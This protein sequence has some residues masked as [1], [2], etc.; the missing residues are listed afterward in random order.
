MRIVV[1]PPPEPSPMPSFPLLRLLAPLVVLAL[2]PGCRDDAAGDPADPVTPA[3]GSVGRYRKARDARS[4]DDK[5]D[6]LEGVGYL[7]GSKQAGLRRGV[8]AHDPDRAAAGP[9]LYLSGH[10]P[11]AVLMDMDGTRLHE[12]RYDFEDAFPGFPT[13]KME[14]SHMRQYWRRAWLSERG[15]LLAIFEGH[16]MLKLSPTSEL[17]WTFEGKPHHDLEVT[18]DGEIYVLTRTAHVIPRIHPTEPVLEDFVSVLDRDGNETRRVSVLEAFENS[19]FA[20]TLSRM[21]RHG[22]LLHTNTIE[23]LDG[24]LA[25]AVPAFAAGNVL[26][27]CLKTSTIAVIDL[28]AAQVVWAMNGSFVR[29]HQPTVLDNGRLLLFDNLGGKDLTIGRSRVLELDPATRE[30]AWSYEGTAE[31]PFQ[32]DTC[33]SCQRMPNGNTV[34]TES[35]YGRAFEVTPDGDIVWEFVNPHRAGPRNDLIA[36]LFELVRLPPDFPVDWI[37]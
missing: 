33:G 28:D 13:D 29:Q 14:K 27:S 19:G 37:P 11:S 16:A 15:E 35:D 23:L 20:H 1:S 21:P 3:D 10:R 6:D 12:W 7:Q 34:I 8:T 17:L 25:D 5:I 32:S 18:D 9:N 4:L 30:I 22:D 2:S 26:I 36:T 31:A 24:R